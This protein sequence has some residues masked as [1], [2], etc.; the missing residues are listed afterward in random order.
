[1]YSCG[2]GGACGTLTNRSLFIPLLA[3]IVILKIPIIPGKD[4]TR[5]DLCTVASTPDGVVGGGVMLT[6]ESWSSMFISVCC[7]SR[8][9]R[10]LFPPH[11][12]IQKEHES[13]ASNEPIRAKPTISHM[14]SL[15]ELE[16]SAESDSLEEWSVEGFV[17]VLIFPNGFLA[18]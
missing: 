18:V 5:S 12:K 3:P 8:F 14:F 2:G 6:R 10:R 13:N 7:S 4:G 9:L 16:F 1:L 11:R 17:V 15:E